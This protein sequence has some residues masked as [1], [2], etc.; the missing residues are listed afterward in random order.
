[1]EHVTEW[2]KIN[3]MHQTSGAII[4]LTEGELD[5][6][7]EDKKKNSLIIYED[8]CCYVLVCTGKVLNYDVSQV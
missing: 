8:S 3:D 7:V 2:R 1:M 5:Q 6:R 4:I